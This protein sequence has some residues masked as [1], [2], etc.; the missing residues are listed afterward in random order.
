MYT[1]A[2]VTLEYDDG[3]QADESEYIVKSGGRGHSY[4]P[5]NNL[6][7]R[8]HQ[9]IDDNILINRVAAGV[10]GIYQNRADESAEDRMRI[11]EDEIIKRIKIIQNFVKNMDVKYNR[12]KTS[13]KTQQTQ[14]DSHRK[15]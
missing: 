13:I 11:F 14:Q 8:L 4:N 3:G 9:T 10:R 5:R 2:P 6:G 7:A 1:R 15:L 12:L